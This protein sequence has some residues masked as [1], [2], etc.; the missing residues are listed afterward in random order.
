MRRISPTLLAGALTASVLLVLAGTAVLWPQD[1][2]APAISSPAPPT[3][4]PA[5]DPATLQQLVDGIVAAGA[6]GAAAL[7]RTGQATWQGA[8]GLGDLRTR[9]P[10]RSTDRFR[11]GSV[12][13][14][15]VAT[16]VLQLVA[17]GRLRLD[18][19]LQRWLPG[20]V[21]GGERITIRQLL[22]HTSGLYNYTDDLLQP[23]TAKPAR[24]A[25]QQMAARNFQ[26]QELMAIAASHPPLFSPG[27]RFAY[28]NTNYILLGLVVER[29]TG[30][31]LAVQLHQRI[32][33]PLKLADTELPDTHQGIR[34]PHVHGY[35][36]PDQSWLPSD[37][38]AGLVDVTQTNPSWSWAA[39]AMVSSATDLARFYQAL[40]GG[41][42]LGPGLLEAMRTTVDASEQF[43]AGA[44]YGLGLL[45]L[46]FGCDGEVWGHGGE[47]PGYATA[48]F[49]TRDTTRQLVL[50]D[51]LL[52][53]PGG[54]VQAAMEHALTEGLTC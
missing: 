37:G 8:S 43:G 34:G 17:E 33:A 11:I 18:H 36:P 19:S 41:R 1:R 30:D 20:V 40:L 4:R 21:P 14:S 38:S 27:T 50:M 13:K 5:P 39:G 3:T 54:A 26:P 16:V 28:S 42:L 46:P 22:N 2:P 32:L 44:G 35:A 7:V 49:S 53:A 48:A 25:L 47:L 51:N 52:P 6:P 23:L 24:Q 29:V 9:Q 45:R 31:R 12:T 10:P 15:F